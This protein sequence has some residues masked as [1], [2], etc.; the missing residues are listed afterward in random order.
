MVNRIV[1]VPIDLDDINEDDL[2]EYLE[3]RGYLVE[4]ED[5]SSDDSDTGY[6][7]QA[8][9]VVRYIND[10][11]EETLLKEVLYEYLG[12][13]HFNDVDTLCEELKKKLS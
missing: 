12:M 3:D 7:G 8:K 9:S 2:V 13:G 4:K 6:N 10:N 11:G 1:E 5:L